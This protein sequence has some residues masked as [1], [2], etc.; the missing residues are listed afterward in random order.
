MFVTSGLKYINIIQYLK[1]LAFHKYR[2]FFISTPPG[3]LGMP[4][5]TFRMPLGVLRMPPGTFRP[6]SGTTGMAPGV[7]GMP[8][9]T[10]GMPSGTLGMASGAFRPPSDHSDPRPNVPTRVG[11]KF[12]HLYIY[13]NLFIC[14]SLNQILLQKE[15]ITKNCCIFVKN[16]NH[17]DRNKEINNKRA[18][19]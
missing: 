5:G 19:S 6:P 3:V 4:F 8:S 13:Y 17:A 15:K 12:L 11:M 9:G 16:L 10:T 18:N 1:S 2:A 14:S 7:V